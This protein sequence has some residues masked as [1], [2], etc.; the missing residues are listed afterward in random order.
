MNDKN[1]VI[2]PA[3]KSRLK[4]EAVEERIAKGEAPVLIEIICERVHCVM[5]DYAINTVDM[6]AEEFGDQIEI[7]TVVRRD[8]IKNVTR[9]MKICKKAGRML[10]VPTILIN[11]DVLFTTI[12]LPDE[13]TDAIKQYLEKNTSG[14]HRK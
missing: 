12:P 8:G 1:D 6:V 4:L 14:A 7:Q 10:S 2:K 13:L 9:F 5:Y 11:G 3:Q